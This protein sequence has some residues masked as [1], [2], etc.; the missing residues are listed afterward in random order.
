MD[1]TKKSINAIQILMLFKFVIWGKFWRDRLLHQ[2][3]FAQAGKLENVCC[4][5]NNNIV[6]IFII[7]AT[8]C[9]NWNILMGISI[10]IY[11]ESSSISDSVLSLFLFTFFYL[12]LNKC[13]TD[14]VCVC[15]CTAQREPIMR[16]VI[17]IKHRHNSA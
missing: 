2:I 17:K 12:L 14:C 9:V 3:F 16:K 4:E 10:A 15:V 6:Q 5:E 1:L 7:F 13:L 8:N 11:L